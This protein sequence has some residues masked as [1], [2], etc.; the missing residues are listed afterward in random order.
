MELILTKFNT[1]FTKS[2][3]FRKGVFVILIEIRLP[4]LRTKFEIY[5]SSQIINLG[6]LM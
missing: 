1:T 6:Q 2:E 4:H 5:M 3:G